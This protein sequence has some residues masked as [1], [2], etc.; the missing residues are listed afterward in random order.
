MKWLIGLP[1]LFAIC[2]VV[3]TI[4]LQP[5]SFL[6]CGERPDTTIQ[7]GAADAIVVVS[8][9]DTPARTQA[10][11]DLYQNGWADVL[12]LSGGGA[13]HIGPEQCRGYEATSPGFGCAGGRYSH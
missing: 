10:G 12:I 11:I 6:G 5:N 1:V 7:C 13:R 8:G 9:G 2:I 4:Y 3:L